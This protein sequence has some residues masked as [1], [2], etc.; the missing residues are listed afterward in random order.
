MRAARGTPDV[1][2]RGR[3]VAVRPGGQISLIGVLSGATSELNVIPVFMKQIRIQGLLVG[4]RES[5][6]AMNRAIALHRMRPVIDRTFDFDDLPAA[7]EHLKS[8][9]HFGKIVLRVE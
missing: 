9:G 5:F 7:L 2:R 8:Q 6:E 3:P 4:S 1:A